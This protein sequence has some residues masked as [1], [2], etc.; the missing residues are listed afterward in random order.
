[1]FVHVL[2]EAQAGRLTRAVMVSTILL[3]DPLAGFV[4]V[5]AG[6]WRVSLS[7]HRRSD[8]KKPSQKAGMVWLRVRSNSCLLA[9]PLV[10]SLAGRAWQI[11]LERRLGH[12]RLAGQADSRRCAGDGCQS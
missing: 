11:S 2:L 7:K 4:A 6:A 5:I 12:A 10:L 9:P 8:E 1:M 3:A